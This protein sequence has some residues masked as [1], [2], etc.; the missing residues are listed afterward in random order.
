M[1]AL[2]AKRHEPAFRDFAERIARNSP[3][4]PKTVIVATM[5]KLIH[6]V[7][8]MLKNQSDYDPDMVKPFPKTIRAA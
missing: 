6:V 7:Y 5:R 1:A 8:G 3:K 4:K 2:V